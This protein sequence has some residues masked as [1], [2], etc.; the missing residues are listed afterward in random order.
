MPGRLLVS[1]WGSFWARKT[2]MSWLLYT[3]LSSLGSVLSPIIEI[4]VA[5]ISWRNS[6]TSWLPKPLQIEIYFRIMRPIPLIIGNCFS[7]L[8]PNPLKIDFILTSQLPSP[9]FSGF[10]VYFHLSTYSLAT[11]CNAVNITISPPVSK[12]YMAFCLLGSCL[13]FAIR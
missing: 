8:G 10:R 9:L 2:Q 12:T 1:G 13:W 11:N 7:L 6:L 3:H 5:Y 4:Q